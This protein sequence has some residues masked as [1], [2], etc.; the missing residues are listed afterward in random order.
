MKSLNA[1]RIAAIVTGAALLGAGLA[2]AGPLTFQN[3]PIISNS[4]QPVVQVVIGSSAKPSDGVAAGNIAAA[5]GNLAYTSTPVTGWVNPNSTSALTVSV[6][7]AKYS[8]TGQQVW[9]NESGVT[10][11]TGG[12]YLFSALIGSVLNQGVQLGSPQYTK[13]LQASTSYAFQESTSLTT[14]PSPYTALGS[15]PT[16]GTIPQTSAGS[17]S[18]TGGGVNFASGFSTGGYDNILRV[19]NS[20]FSALANNWGGNGESEN[21]FLTG[22]PVY[23]QANSGSIQNAFALLSVGGA[24]VAT[25]NKPIQNTTSGNSLSINVPIK[26]LGQNFTI[27]NGTGSGSTTVSS[28]V[29]K[30]GGKISLASSV[31]PLQT[32]YVGHN[33][34]SGPWTVQLQDFAQTNQGTNANA[35]VAVYYNGQLTNSSVIIQANKNTKINVTGHLLFI[36]AQQ[37]FAGLYAYQKWAKIQLYAGVYNLQDGRVFNSTND[38]GWYVNLLWTNTSGSGKGDA[39]Q[40]IVI[41]NYTPTSLSQGQSFTFI[42][43]PASFKVTFVGDTLGNNYDQLTTSLNTGSS[44]YYNNGGAVGTDGNPSNITEPTELLTVQSGI[45][46]AF[47]YGGQTSSIITYVLT[48]FELIH[49]ANQVGVGAYGTNVVLS[50]TA[51]GAANTISSSHTVTVQVK[52]Y[53]SSGNAANGIN[54]TEPSLTFTSPTSNQLLTTPLYA[55]TGITISNGRAFPVNSVT[56]FSVTVGNIVGTTGANQLSQLLQIKPLALLSQSNGYN[57]TY[58]TPN[59]NTLYNQQNGQQTNVYVNLGSGAPTGSISQFYTFNVAENPVPQNSVAIDSLG[60]GIYNTT[61]SQGNSQLLQ[62]NYSTSGQ[63]ANATYVSSQ[64]L[65]IPVQAGFRT[66]KGSK[67]ASIGPSQDVFDMATSADMLQFAL[68]NTAGNAV[69]SKSTSTF[70]PYTVGQATNLP[71]VSIAAVNASVVLSGTSKYTV[72]GVNALTVVTS[73]TSATTPVLLKNLSSTAPLVVLDSSANQGSNLILVGSGYVNTLSQQL[74]SA[75]NVQVTPGSAP[76]MQAY[77]GNRILVAGYAAADTQTAAN[78]FI[79]Q[80][81]TLAASSG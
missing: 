25:F 56:N 39:L 23:D 24:Y 38:K 5:I 4:G 34:T 40:G 78:N 52:G 48:P 33:I 13:A 46:N 53:T 35:S 19:T 70:G 60:F 15:V 63:H 29:T 18:N 11:A 22:F 12:T 58:T 44:T 41:Y 49:T 75:Y 76:I 10:S 14:T 2:F 47:S 81:Y 7:S 71:N 8:L 57:K 74:E 9:L 42:Q 69:V 17:N 64:A 28:S 68:T 31:A 45:T 16:G 3:V 80:L 6:S 79:N 59:G 61:G 1:K 77:G 67:V 27:V 73:V 43:N 30:N 72:T 51:P 62:M 37:T 55:V 66:E 50:Y 32:V 54:T 21:L 65:A 26:L 36:S 20:Q